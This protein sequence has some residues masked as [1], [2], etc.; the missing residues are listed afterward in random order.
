MERLIEGW[1]A[2]AKQAA[3]T[4]MR[5]YGPPNEMTP[6]RLI[7]FNNAPWKR[8]VVHRDEVPHDFPVPHADV[9]EQVINYPVPAD[10]VG[11]VGLFDKSVIIAQTMGEVSAC[12]DN[13]A[14]N[15]LALN[16]VHEIVSGTKT[17][18][19][20]RET[21]SEQITAWLMNRPAPYAEDFQFA[22]PEEQFQTD[23]PA[24]QH[25]IVDQAIKKVK[26]FFS[27]DEHK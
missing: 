7:W 21:A 3:E 13:E 15:V 20:A 26:D 9:L 18:E 11:E 27:G 16:M 19:Q 25:D 4:T 17:P 23:E 2:T 24:V 12:C 5:F 8:T 22:L 14:S 1:P 6:S 10:K